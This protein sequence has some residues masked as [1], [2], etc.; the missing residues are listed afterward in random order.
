LQ[1]LIDGNNLL[2]AVR[3]AGLGPP[4][5]REGLC[6]LVSAWAR[7]TET[8]T[9]VVFDGLAPQTALAQQLQQPGITLQFSGPESADSVIE[10]YV[11]RATVPVEITVVTTDRAI[12]HAVR[13]RRARAVDSQ[14]FVEQLYDRPQPDSPPTAPAPEKPDEISAAEAEEW[15]TRFSEDVEGLPD[16]GP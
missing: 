2:H 7:R 8:A 12:Q 10:D 1:Y 15:L 9:T 14:S 4:V 6:K 11:A 5:G 3:E 16:N 13:Y